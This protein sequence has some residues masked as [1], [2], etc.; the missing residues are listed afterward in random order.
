MQ[1]ERRQVDSTNNGRHTASNF[2]TLAG[3]VFTVLGKE[4]DPNSTGFLASETFVAGATRWSLSA[5]LRS[6]ACGRR[7]RFAETRGRAVTNCWP[8]ARMA[9]GREVVLLEFERRGKEALA[10][11]VLVDGPRTIFA[12]FTAEFQGEGQ[13]LWRVDDGGQLSPRGF[14][15]V[16]VLQRGDWYALGT[17]WA[18]AEGKSLSL[19]ISAGR[20]RFTKAIEDYWDQAPI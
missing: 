6:D 9:P 2:D 18:G 20:E 15:I 7:D 12:D 13:S 4:V 11:V 10:S 8:L 3:S 19:W 1:F 5:P 16:C 17:A 14:D